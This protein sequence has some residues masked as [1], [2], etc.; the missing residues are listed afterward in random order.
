MARQYGQ[1]A[2]DASGAAAA[3]ANADV[4]YRLRSG[5]QELGRS[6][7]DLVRA[8]GTCQMAPHGD[9]FATRDVADSARHVSEK[10]LLTINVK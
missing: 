10:V 3:T 2:G 1:L 5:V 8:A 9:S 6:C 4:S 7:H